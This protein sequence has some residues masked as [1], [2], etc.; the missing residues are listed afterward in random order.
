MPID[1]TARASESH[2][3][4]ILHVD[5]AVVV[6][7]EPGIVSA[8]AIAATEVSYDPEDQEPLLALR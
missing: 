8:R 6:H 7:V 2:L 1:A 4:E 5:G 3:Q